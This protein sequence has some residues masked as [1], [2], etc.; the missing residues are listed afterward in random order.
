MSV[1]IKVSSIQFAK[2]VN[3][4]ERAKINKISFAFY[5]INNTFDF[6]EGTFA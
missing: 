5:P 1:V 3:P 4:N 2:V 6:V